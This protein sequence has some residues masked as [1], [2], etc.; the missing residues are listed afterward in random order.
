MNPLNIG[1]AVLKV[2]SSNLKHYILFFILFLT[3][4]VKILNRHQNNYKVPHM[5]K[6]HLEREITLPN[7]VCGDIDTSNEVLAL[8]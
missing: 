4:L 3:L 7:Q 1:L 5:K 2:P 6:D 8:L